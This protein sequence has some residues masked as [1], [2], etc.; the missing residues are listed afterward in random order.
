MCKDHRHKL[1][2]TIHELR[3]AM[4]TLKR[5]ERREERI[6]SRKGSARSAFPQAAIDIS[7][8]DLYNDTEDIIQDV[9]ADI[10][11]WGGKAPILLRKLTS[12][13]GRLYDAPNSGRDYRHLTDALQRVRERITPQDEH[14]IYGHCLNTTCKK[15]LSGP[16]DAQTAVCPTCG[17]V[18]TIKAVREARRE[19]L[20][21]KIITGTPTQIALW[22]KVQTGVNVKSQDVRNWLRRGRLTK[23]R[24]IT[25]GVYEF[26]LEQL[27]ACVEGDRSERKGSN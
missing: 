6:E 5:V 24:K 21:G 19:I 16:V 2:S 17:S 7:A 10:G 1:A 23:S 3:L 12:R 8:A 4:E 14:I 22:V 18:W 20:V 25:R 15:T 26:D 9:A 11:L 27:L 13:I